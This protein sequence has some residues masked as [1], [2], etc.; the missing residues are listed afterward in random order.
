MLS[1]NIYIGLISIPFILIVACGGGG[2][3]SSQSSESIKI[4]GE[5]INPDVEGTLFFQNNSNSA[6]LMD[7]NTG[8]YSLIANTNWDVR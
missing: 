1:S 2:S 3:S 5:I 4:G 8:K 6:Y 7:L